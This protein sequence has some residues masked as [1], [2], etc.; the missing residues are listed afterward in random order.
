MG[1]TISSTEPMVT[2][3]PAVAEAETVANAV[4]AAAAAHES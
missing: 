2:L 1:E 4:G 3:P